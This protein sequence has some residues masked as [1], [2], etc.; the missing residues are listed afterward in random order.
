[1]RTRYAS[2]DES[3]TTRHTSAFRAGPTAAARSRPR[4]SLSVVMMTDDRGPRGPRRGGHTVALMLAAP[5]NVAKPAKILVAASLRLLS[6]RMRPQDACCPSWQEGQH[7]GVLSV[8]GGRISERA[9]APRR[10]VVCRALPPDTSGSR[11]VSPQLVTAPGGAA[12]PAAR[13]AQ[14]LSI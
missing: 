7:A 10:R 5:V 3:W 1:M 11:G 12:P 14:Q 4:D 13:R 6:P 8:G 9:Y 2:Q